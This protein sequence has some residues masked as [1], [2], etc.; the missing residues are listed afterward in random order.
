MVVFGML[1]MLYM[2]RRV[3]M[4]RM[5]GIRVVVNFG[6]MMMQKELF[7]EGMDWVEI[8]ALII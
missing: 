6:V 1:R 8:L 7:I 4:A 5:R 3:W 2:D